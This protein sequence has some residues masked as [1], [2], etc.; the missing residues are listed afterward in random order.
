[1]FIGLRQFVSSDAGKKIYDSLIQPHFDYCC[2]VWNGINNQLT[3]KLQKLQNRAAR[4]ITKSSYEVSSS[5]LL[6]ALGWDKLISDRQKPKTIMVFKSLHNLTSVYLHNMFCKFN[7]DYGLRNSI[8]KLTL[9]KARTVYLKRGFSYSGA[10]LWNSLPQALRECNS[11][12]VFK[13]KVKAYF[14]S[15]GSHTAI[16]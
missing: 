11:L 2:T 1:M 13:K 12:G 9:P 3:E 10:A 8:N 7:T 14:S 4:V 6:D 5:L 15:L 16:T